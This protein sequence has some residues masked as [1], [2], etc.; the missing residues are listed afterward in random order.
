MGY[1]GNT[2][3]VWEYIE[4]LCIILTMILANEMKVKFVDCQRKSDSPPL[5]RN[6]LIKTE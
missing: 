1:E 4:K 2:K 3:L 6:Y 5:L